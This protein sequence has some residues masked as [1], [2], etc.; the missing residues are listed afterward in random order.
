LT[1]HRKTSSQ[2]VMYAVQAPDGSVRIS[3][4]APA[5]LGTINTMVLLDRYEVE[6]DFG[7]VTCEDSK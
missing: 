6:V 7:K 3:L 5:D 2:D 4:S 1:T